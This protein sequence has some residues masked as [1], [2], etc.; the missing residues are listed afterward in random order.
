MAGFERN[1]AF[2]FGVEAL[3]V[4]APEDIVGH[5]FEF[6]RCRRASDELGLC[7]VLVKELGSLGLGDEREIESQSICW[8][9]MR[10]LLI[11]DVR[12][13]GEKVGGYVVEGR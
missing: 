6:V 8:H 1:E 7:E 2:L 13:E 10:Y 3:F 9:C 5:C 12:R 11:D 4:F